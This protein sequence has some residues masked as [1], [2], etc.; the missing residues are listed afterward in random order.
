VM[1]DAAHREY[2]KRPAANGWPIIAYV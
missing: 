2:V 1:N